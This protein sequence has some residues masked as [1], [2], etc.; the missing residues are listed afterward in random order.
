M[1]NPLTS[2]W[3]P[4]VS[5]PEKAMFEMTSEEVIEEID[6]SGLRG[7]GGG[8]FSDRTQMETGGTPERKSTL[9]RM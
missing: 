1:Q 2:T 8:G 5:L 6:K 9:C 7:R 3:H 4:A